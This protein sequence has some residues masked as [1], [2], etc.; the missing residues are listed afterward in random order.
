[1]AKSIKIFINVSP[2][3]AV[4]I[5]WGVVRAP[6]NVKLPVYD[7]VSLRI[8]PISEANVSSNKNV[9]SASLN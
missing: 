2:L 8:A 5:S 9:L 4:M 1:M 7:M 6:S 3:L